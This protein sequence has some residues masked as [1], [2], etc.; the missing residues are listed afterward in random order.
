MS[1]RIAIVG[2]PNVGKST[3]FNRLTGRRRALVD[4][5]PGLTRDRREGAGR[6]YDLR[7]A[8]IDTAG[9]E[10]AAPSSLAGRMRA[11][12]MK[13]VEDCDLALF[14]LDARAGVTPQDEHFARALRK[15]GKPVLVIAN[16]VETGS[17]TDMAVAE[18]A[19]LGLGE[20][21]AIS[22]EHGEGMSDLH[23]ELRA[24]APAD[25]VVAD[26]ADTDETE[27]PAGEAAAPAVEPAI[28]IALIG[29][30]NVGKSTL[31]NALLGEE[32]ML[33]GPEPGI[34]RDAIA[35]PFAWRG[36]EFRL[37]D[38]AGLRKK[39]RIDESIERLSV[40]ET[41]KTVREAHVCVLVLD[42]QTM[43]ENQDLQIARLAVEEGRA[44]VVAVN[45]WDLIEDP[46]AALRKLRDRI[47]ISMPQ[48]Q[49]VA[50]VTVSALHGRKLDD[51]MKAVVGAHERWNADLS[52]PKLNR[53]LEGV[54]QAHPPPLVRGLRPRLRFCRQ[55]GVRPPTIALFGN[56]LT[57]LP[58]DYQR[59]LINSLRET[60]DLPGTVV[61]LQLR[62]GKN[63]Y[64]SD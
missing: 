50:F 48:V 9:L 43:L 61:R 46:Q 49:G 38:T 58:G 64:A 15:A 27:M 7:F 11:Q 33:T 63:P 25:A 8:L 21:L 44:I 57:E 60:F 54:T 12:S 17:K 10:E 2:R 1:W 13:A 16:K 28:R 6:L 40:G 55:V 23:A 35:V 29:R 41:I 51:L 53:W 32:R 5:T 18:A 47:E 31:A 59:Y 20:A 4:D 34:T 3:L 45:K 36:R 14:V 42:A 52:T 56:K 39:A 24:R 26:D 22:A 62:A 19:G 37:I 30:P